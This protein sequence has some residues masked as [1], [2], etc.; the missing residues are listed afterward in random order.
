MRSRPLMPP[1]CH[2]SPA[3]A[4][5][6]SL[7]RRT[8]LGRGALFL[9]VAALGT[10]G[11]ARIDHEAFIAQLVRLTPEADA[12]NAIGQAFLDR[13]SAPSSRLMAER[14]GVE[15]DWQPELDDATIRDQVPISTS[16]FATLGGSVE[17]GSTCSNSYMRLFERDFCPSG[18]SLADP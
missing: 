2:A 8:L 3:M 10:G 13:P 17:V 18:R 9:G 5:D 12:A 16:F 15:L 14:L 1:M 11:C 6:R 7:T 4:L